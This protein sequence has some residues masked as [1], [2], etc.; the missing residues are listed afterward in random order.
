MAKKTN[1][2]EKTTF[3]QKYRIQQH[4]SR[5][6]QRDGNNDSHNTAKLTM[7]IE[8]FKWNLVTFRTQ[9]VKKREQNRMRQRQGAD[10]REHNAG[11]VFFTNN[12]RP[13]REMN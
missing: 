4:S 9:I 2:T 3:Y 10:S 12:Q 11:Q 5:M 13:F 1:E 6:I 7:P 8:S